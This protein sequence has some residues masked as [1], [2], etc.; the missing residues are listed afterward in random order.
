MPV[1][2]KLE[3]MATGDWFWDIDRQVAVRLD[4]AGRHDLLIGPYPT[5]G[6]AEIWM[7]SSTW[8]SRRTVDS[9]DGWVDINS[10][11]D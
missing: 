8:A 4:N 3:S 2:D 1:A 6:D 7:P 10:A 5:Q 9:G 11:Y